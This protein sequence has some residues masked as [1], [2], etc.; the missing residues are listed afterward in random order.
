MAKKTE[1]KDGK[2]GSNYGGERYRIPWSAGLDAWVGSETGKTIHSPNA[3]TFEPDIA[4]H[5]G[6]DK[7][8]DGK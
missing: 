1:G 4:L 7:L 6:Y 8:W 2:V 5:K 3:T